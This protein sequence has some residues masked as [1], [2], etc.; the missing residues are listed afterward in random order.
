MDKLMDI[1]AGRALSPAEM[2]ILP[3]QAQRMVKGVMQHPMLRDAHD[4]PQLVAIDP[5]GD[6]P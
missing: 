4:V 2:A 5:D 1:L 6:R 3:D